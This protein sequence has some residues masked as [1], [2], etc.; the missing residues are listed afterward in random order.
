M[1]IVT[2]HPISKNRTAKLKKY[3][4]YNLFFIKKYE[5]KIISN[6]TTQKY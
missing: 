5:Q 6:A 2:L 3:H 1:N 4:A